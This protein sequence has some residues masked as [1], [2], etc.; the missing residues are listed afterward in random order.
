MRTALFVDF[1]NIAIS[2]A[3]LDETAARRFATQP[4]RWLAWFESG[5]ATMRSDFLML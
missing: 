3:E 2:F 4:A 1:D 5:P